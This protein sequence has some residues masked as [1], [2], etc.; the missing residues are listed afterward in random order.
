MYDFD[1]NSGHEN[2]TGGLLIFVGRFVIFVVSYPICM[3]QDSVPAG[4]YNDPFLSSVCKM[5]FSEVTI[6]FIN[7]SLSWGIS[8]ENPRRAF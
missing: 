6:L 4:S 1:D 5:P 3:F 8:W 7:V 2:Q